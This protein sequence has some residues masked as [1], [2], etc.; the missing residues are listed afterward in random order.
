[1]CTAEQ[2]YS[3]TEE[4]DNLDHKLA[5]FQD[6]CRR[7]KLPPQEHVTAFPAILKGAASDHYH[8]HQL[9]NRSMDEICDNLRSFFEGSGYQRKVL[10]KWTS[11]TLPSVIAENPTAKTAESLRILIDRL[12]K[13]QYGLNP[14]LRTPAFLHHKLIT[15]CQ[16]VTACQFAVSDPPEDLGFFTNKL[17]SSIITYEAQQA[18]RAQEGQS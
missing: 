16:G 10:D 2:Q 13:M 17:Y 1:M 18:Q 12:R 7:V 3:G 9:F 6:L 8:T 14:Q 4:N 11:T 5:I 15:A